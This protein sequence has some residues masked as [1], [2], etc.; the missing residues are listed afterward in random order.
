MA[1]SLYIGKQGSGKSYEIVKSVI[2]PA[3]AKGRRVVT[4]VYGLNEAGIHDYCIR[5]KLCTSD[6]TMGAVIPVDNER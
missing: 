4:N 2:I 5:H 6:I 1:I 3:I